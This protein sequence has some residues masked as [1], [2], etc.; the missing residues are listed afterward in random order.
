MTFSF[1]L[2]NGEVITLRM[3][4]S[5]ENSM[6]ITGSDKEVAKENFEGFME[7]FPV[8]LDER[9]RWL[10]KYHQVEASLKDNPHQSYVLNLMKEHDAPRSW[11]YNELGQDNCAGCAYSFRIR[12]ARGYFIHPALIITG[13]S[14]AGSRKIFTIDID[15][16]IVE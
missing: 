15:L 7:K 2:S 16:D 6:T 11:V 1:Q 14:F 4:K 8:W 10:E 3:P 13:Y 12:P 9:N 5:L